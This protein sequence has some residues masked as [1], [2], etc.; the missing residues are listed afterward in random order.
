MPDCG[1]A[2]IVILT[3]F[4]NVYARTLWWYYVNE[5]SVRRVEERVSLKYV[6]EHVVIS[7][8]IK[9]AVPRDMVACLAYDV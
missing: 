9:L 6:L 2:R 1:K 5:L 3:Q 7:M 8:T 4:S